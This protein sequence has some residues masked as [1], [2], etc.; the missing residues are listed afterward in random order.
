MPLLQLSEGFPNVPKKNTNHGKVEASKSNVNKEITDSNTLIASPTIWGERNNPWKKD[1]IILPG[2]EPQS[3]P[4]PGA[5]KRAAAA[6]THASFPATYP[7]H[8]AMVPPG[9]FIRLPAIKSAPYTA[10]LLIITIL[11]FRKIVREGEICSIP[12]MEAQCFLQTPHNNCPPLPS[13]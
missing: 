5:D 10:I 8:G 12:H 4:S 3:T 13:S 2:V 9:F 6:L 7:P 1:R 11:F